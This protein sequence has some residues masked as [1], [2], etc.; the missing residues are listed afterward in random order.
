MKRIEDYFP[1]GDE[2]DR[3]IQKA[4][5]EIDMASAVALCVG[6]GDKADMIYRNLSSPVYEQV[7]EEMGR[8]ESTFP[9]ARRSAAYAL[10]QK[11]LLKFEKKG[12]EQRVLSEPEELRFDTFEEIRQSLHH[13][14]N[15][16]REGQIGTMER[17]IGEVSDPALRRQLETVLFAEDPLTAEAIIDRMA[18]RQKER[19]EKK[20][21]LLKEG[22]ISLLVGEGEEIFLEKIY[23]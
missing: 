15:L 6:L 1:P 9:A 4:L 7:K 22:L 8:M 20:Q 14:Y 12:R 13:L 10:F 17:M 23:D 21:Y 11:K 19:F 2:H 5:R 3:M 18:S 16:N